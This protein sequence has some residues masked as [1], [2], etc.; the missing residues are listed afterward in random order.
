MSCAELACLVQSTPDVGSMLEIGTWCGVTA[1]QVKDHHPSIYIAC[2][3][4]FVGEA[5]PACEKAWHDNAVTGM[6][7]FKGTIQGYVAKVWDG[8]PFDLIVVDG[9][10]TF[11]GATTDLHYAKSL[12]KPKGLIAV[13]DYDREPVERAVYDF[14]MRTGFTI[15][16][17][18]D[19]LAVLERSK[20]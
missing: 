17:R 5:G 14:T 12:V 18:C 11:N 9:D 8:S 19:N 15:K 16:E 3:D 1:C 6:M 13:H 10:H 4:P 2:V 20:S 7:L